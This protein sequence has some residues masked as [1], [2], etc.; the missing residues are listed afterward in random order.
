M[1]TIHQALGRLRIVRRRKRGLELEG[2]EGG[3]GE[4]LPAGFPGE[5]GILADAGLEGIV[6]AELPVESGDDEGGATHG[7]PVVAD[8][9]PPRAGP[10]APEI[11]EDT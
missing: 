3:S 4:E 11:R 7:N 10:G 1:M 5:S 2:L 6:E 8:G 9:F